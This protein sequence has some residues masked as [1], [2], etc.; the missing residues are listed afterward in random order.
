MPTLLFNV[1]SRYKDCLKNTLSSVKYVI[2]LKYYFCNSYF[3]IILS[4]FR[5]LHQY[6]DACYLYC[7]VIQN[8]IYLD[9]HISRHFTL[10]VSFIGKHEIIKHFSIIVWDT[11]PLC[12]MLAT[13][14]KNERKIARAQLLSVRSVCICVRSLRAFKQLGKENAANVQFDRTSGLGNE[15]CKIELNKS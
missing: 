7:T 13:K 14:L 11:W 8:W 4:V 15:F 9:M 2:V 12:L 1:T 10:I 3:S 6:K 5:L